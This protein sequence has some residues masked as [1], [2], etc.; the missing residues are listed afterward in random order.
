MMGLAL[1]YLRN[2]KG[3]ENDV[4]RDLWEW[5]RNG[6]WEGISNELGN[7]Y[8]VVIWEG[9]WKLLGKGIWEEDLGKGYMR[10]LAIRTAVW[11]C[12]SRIPWPSRSSSFSVL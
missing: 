8:W 12:L 10:G 1:V 11:V 4:T 6:I 5:I 9:T 2:G 7:K 3:M